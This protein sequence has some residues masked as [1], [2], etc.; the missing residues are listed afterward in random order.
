MTKK[1]YEGEDG[2][3]A[4]FLEAKGKVAQIAKESKDFEEFE[5]NVLSDKSLLISKRYLNVLIQS[6]AHELD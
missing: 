5:K 4:A 2:R 6:H 1:T 3:I